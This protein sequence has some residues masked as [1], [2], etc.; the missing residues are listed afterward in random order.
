MQA[1]ILLVDDALEVLEKLARYLQKE[2]YLVSTASTRAQAIERFDAEDPDLCIVDYEL[3]DGTGFDVMQE[4][5]RRD[6]KAGFV[7]LTGHATISLAVD[8]MKLGA[9][10]FLTKPVNLASLNVIVERALRARAAQRQRSVQERLEQRAR[11]DPFVGESAAIQRVREQAQ[12]VVKADATVL[13]SGETGSGKGVLARWLHAAGTRAEHAF[14]DLNCAGLTREITESELFGQQRTA[15]DGGDAP[16]NGLLELAHAGTLFL[17]EVG[18]LDLAV[19]P[20]LLKVLEDKTY[21]RI[22]DVQT[23]TS[24]VRLITSTHRDLAQ[25]AQ[26]G[27]FRSDLLFRI[28]TVEIRLPALR[29]R[30]QDIRALAAVVLAQLCRAQG[31]A[32]VQLSEAA[33][34]R[35]EQYAWPG[36]VRELR[37]VLER[38][39]L[40]CP[41]SQISDELIGLRPAS[42]TVETPAGPRATLEEVER[43]HITAVMRDV[44]DRVD[45]A[46]RILGIP[47]SSLYA[48]L[49]R[50]GG[51]RARTR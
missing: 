14:V 35:L 13:L 32:P 26:A 12:I 18:D 7:M 17:D 36:N 4:I 28:N 3:P 29:D 19:Q 11:I 49:K 22:G 42:A 51:A 23:R 10:H 21:R 38:A 1:R 46:A 37:N 6:P 8:A 45:E 48:K 50:Y 15:A 33:V 16:R 47:R 27:R 39:L 31:R 20:K 25:L 40:F 30:R 41:G 34:L 9:D 44:G 2:G 43:V 5:Q 24:D